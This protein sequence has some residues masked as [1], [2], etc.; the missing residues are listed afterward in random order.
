M[1]HNLTQLQDYNSAVA[2][3]S[4]KRS[5]SLSQGPQEASSNKRPEYLHSLENHE[6]LLFGD[7][8][9]DAALGDYY[10]RIH[11]SLPILP[12]RN[13]LFAL[14]T[15]CTPKVREAFFYALTAATSAEQ[16]IAQHAARLLASPE[17]LSSTSLPA[18]LVYLT[19]LVFLH[20]A[21]DAIGPGGIF[22][23]PV[24]RPRW[25]Q[26]AVG[27]SLSLKL[28]RAL[29]FNDPVT[30]DTESDYGIGRRLFWIIYILDR[31][32]GI[33]TDTALY[34]Q[35]SC[36]FL[37]AEDERVLGKSIFQLAGAPYFPL[38]LL[39]LVLLLLGDCSLA[40]IA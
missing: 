11:S 9:A 25:L 6:E 12:T 26:E 33:S 34:L 1:D 37:Y 23:N 28:N 18:L 14:T 40:D 20:M 21:S 30:A 22:G 10:R 2:Q 27:L 8:N 36:A 35:D 16:N 38:F 17:N 3:P 31:F 4:R 15:S 7:S 13:R 19:S 32:H 5:F 29:D 24:T 39:F